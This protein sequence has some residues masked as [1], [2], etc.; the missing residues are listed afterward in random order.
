[1]KSSFIRHALAVLS[2]VLV[3]S[4]EANACDVCALYTA[5]QV[6][7]PIKNAFRLGVAE[8]FTSMDR[9]KRDGN[10][11]ENT[12]NQFLKSSVTQVSG[13]YDP[14]ASTSLQLVVPVV[15]RTWRRIENNAPE[16]GSDAGI[17]DI[18]MLAHYVPL[19]YSEGS[20]IARLR[21]FG[22]VELPTGDAH[23]LGEESA[24]GH[25]G[26]GEDSDEED[27]SHDSHDESSD[28]ENGHHSFTQKHNGEVHDAPV[29]NAIHGHD[30]TLGSGSWD[31]PLGAG[32]FSQWGN[33]IL[34]S[35]VQYTIRT[36]GAF[37]YRF[38]ND[39]TW[40]AAAGRYLY[41]EDNAQVALRARLSGQYKGYDTGKGGVEYT[42]TAFND[43][44]LGPEV[45]ALVTQRWQAIVGYDLPI[46]VQNSDLQITPS[47]RI[48]AA[49]TYRF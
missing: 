17:G 39:L 2:V 15:S 23:Y 33:Y 18:T 31:F 4:Q 21:V 30:I 40:S 28:Q 49:L 29:E 43:V 24:P 25:H 9:I 19:N 10:Y 3:M 44:F 34:A 8:Q 12:A 32:L 22:G 37:G 46:E 6:E 42:D 16:R 41:L 1:M 27:P 35:D 26:E 20:T 47:Y 36:D 45:T 5:V 38:A 48:R 14:S 7:S 13:Q 11:V